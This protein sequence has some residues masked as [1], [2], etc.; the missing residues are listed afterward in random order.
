MVNDLKQFLVL[1]ANKQVEYLKSP[2]FEKEPREKR[3]IFLK[4]I[5]TPDLS[6]LTTACALR[7]LRTLN[8]PDRYYFR[9]FLYH[10]SSEVAAAAKYA[11]EEC[12]IQQENHGN[13]MVKVM[14]EGISDDRL[15][16]VDFFLQDKGKIN[17]RVLISFLS[18]DDPKVRD[19]IIQKITSGYEFDESQLS[20]AITRGST[21]YL[22][23]ALV[24]ILGKRKSKHLFDHID[25]LINDKN[26]EVK[27]KLVH[28]LQNYELETRKTYLQ[29]L[30]RDSIIWVRKEASRLLQSS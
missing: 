23:A 15:L 22:R 1:K 27:L 28:A 20:D 3:I 18:V 14:E 29:Q 8:Y 13:P 21:W 5:L 24:E 9:K 7:M 4:S 17:E 2:D 12:A 26:V 25:L 19:R 6:P 16:L 10:T 11:M 30:T